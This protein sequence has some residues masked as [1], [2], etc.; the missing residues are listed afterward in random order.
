[1]GTSS[2]FCKFPSVELKHRWKKNYQF[3]TFHFQFLS[4]QIS[5]KYMLL[6]LS[7]NLTAI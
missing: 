6:G 3:Q 2:F 5:D 7:L 4:L 1:L